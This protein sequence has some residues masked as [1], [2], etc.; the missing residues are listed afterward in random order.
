MVYTC[1]FFAAGRFPHPCGL[2]PTRRCQILSVRAEGDGRH[3]IRMALTSVTPA[4]AKLN[5]PKNM[6]F[7]GLL[8]VRRSLRYIGYMAFICKKD[9]Y[10]RIADERRAESF[11][12]DSENFC[13]DLNE[14][15]LYNTGQFK[16]KMPVFSGRCWI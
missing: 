6:A 14:I 4:L 11:F 2:V 7:G 10:S 13:I 1:E 5:H 12:F 16:R 15:Y 8:W 3:T 9:L